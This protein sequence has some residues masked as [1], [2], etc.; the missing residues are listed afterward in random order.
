MVLGL[1][2]ISNDEVGEGDNTGMKKYIFWRNANLVTNNIPTAFNLYQN[3]PNPFNPIT[4][5]KYDL[6]KNVNVTI[7]VYDLIGREVATLVNNELKTAGRYEV[8]W[9]AMNYASGVYIYRI[10]AGDYVSTKKMVLV[11]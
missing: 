3:F 9:N 7:K 2:S 5:I 8:N 1:N 6:P 11:K 10:Q 4:K